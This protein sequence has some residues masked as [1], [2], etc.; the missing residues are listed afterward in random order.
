MNNDFDEVSPARPMRPWRWDDVEFKAVQVPPHPVVLD[1]YSLL[2]A[3]GGLSQVQLADP[4]NFYKQ[5]AAIK[6]PK[7]R[8][9][10]DE[11]KNWI[12]G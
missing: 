5:V 11:V 7:S 6:P 9:F 2:C 8:G 4:I 1:Y 3:M 10:F 12:F